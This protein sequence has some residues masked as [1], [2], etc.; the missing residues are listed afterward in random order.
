MLSTKREVHCM[1]EILNNKFKLKYYQLR[2]KNDMKIR[3]I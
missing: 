2:K 3:G 1:Y